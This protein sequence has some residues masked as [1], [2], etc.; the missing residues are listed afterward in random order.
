MLPVAFKVQMYK[1]VLDSGWVDLQDL[2]VIVGKN[3]AGKT[4]LL[5]AL[6]KFK[7]FRDDPYVINRECRHFFFAFNIA[8]CSSIID[9]LRPESSCSQKQSTP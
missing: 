4:T 9:R 6:H 3:E 2:T 7:P 8:V 5:R 1:G